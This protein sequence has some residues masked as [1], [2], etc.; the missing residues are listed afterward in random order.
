MR[1]LVIRDVGRKQHLE[2]HVMVFHVSVI[3]LVRVHVAAFHL[4]V[5]LI[6]LH[7]EQGCTLLSD[8]AQAL[9]L[10]DLQASLSVLGFASEQDLDWPRLEISVLLGHQFELRPYWLF[11]LESIE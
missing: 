10:A 5:E 6:L 4:H 2:A 1:T 9:E 3:V 7:S 8:G 11:A